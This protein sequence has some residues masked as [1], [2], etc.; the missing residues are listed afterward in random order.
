MKCWGVPTTCLPS[1]RLGSIPILSYHI[2]TVLYLTN[3][4]VKIQRLASRYSF[5][6][7]QVSGPSDT[8]RVMRQHFHIRY[9]ILMHASNFQIENLVF[10][11]F[12]FQALDDHG[13]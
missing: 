10:A 1:Y 2:S 5:S 6:W 11:V 12:A 7:N 3:R 13:P 8:S 4:F 9:K